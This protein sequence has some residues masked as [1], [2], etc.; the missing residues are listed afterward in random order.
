MEF[1]S[2]SNPK[3]IIGMGIDKNDIDIFFSINRLRRM[4]F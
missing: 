2:G 4:H 1:K 3:L